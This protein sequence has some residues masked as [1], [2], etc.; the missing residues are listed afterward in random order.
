LK[1]P[2]LI[3]QSQVAVLIGNSQAQELNQITPQQMAAA[4]SARSG[5][6]VVGWLDVPMLIPLPQLGTHKEVRVINSV[7]RQEKRSLL[8]LGLQLLSGTWIQRFV[9]S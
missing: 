2:K 7:A 3:S 5:Q 9:C 1:K 4:L 8:R 6:I